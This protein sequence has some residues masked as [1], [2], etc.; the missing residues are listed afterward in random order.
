[1]NVSLTPELEVLV[2]TK[3]ASGMYNSASEVVR[4]GL[5]L[6]QQRDELFQKKLD[7]LRA[8]VRLGLDDLEAGRLVDGHIAMA[9]RRTRILKMKNND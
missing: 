5:R 8:D 6:I 9:N 2:N 4:D 7:A 3:V 1:M